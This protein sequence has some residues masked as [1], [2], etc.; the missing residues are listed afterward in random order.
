MAHCRTLE[1]SASQFRQAVSSEQDRVTE[2]KAEE[3]ELHRKH[4]MADKKLK[5]LQSS[6]SNNLRRFANWMPTLV[7]KIEEAYRGGH[8]HQKP[9]G[10]IGVYLLLTSCCCCC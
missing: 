7:R 5:D 9:R 2:L 8:F 4:D 10:P 6:R 1:Y 3:R